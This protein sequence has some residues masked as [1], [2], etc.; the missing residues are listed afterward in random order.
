MNKYGEG[1]PHLPAEK[2]AELPELAKLG[3]SGGGFEMSLI[4][5]MRAMHEL[6]PK[7]VL[8]SDGKNGAYLASP[9]GLIF[10]PATQVKVAGTAGA[11]DALASTFAAFI[12][13]GAAPEDAIR[14]GII[15]SGSVIT[16]ID[17]QSGLLKR[18]PLD[19]RL[20]EARK[21]LA[22]RNWAL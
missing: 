15:N 19:K 17:T 20:A 14:A 1:G 3:L 6:G 5:F 21:T 7:W 16:F 13:D 2:G 11:G 10:C 9:G 4:A 12:A 8:V 18:A 22:I